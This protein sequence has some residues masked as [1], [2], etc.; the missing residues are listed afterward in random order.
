M[1]DREI[2]RIQRVVEWVD[3]LAHEDFCRGLFAPGTCNC[4]RG[5]AMAELKALVDEN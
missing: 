2:P 1:N 5:N 4:A 3:A